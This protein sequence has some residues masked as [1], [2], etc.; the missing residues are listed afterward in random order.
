MGTEEKLEEERAVH[1]KVSD[2]SNDSG[3]VDSQSVSQSDLLGATSLSSLEPRFKPIT[4]L[5]NSRTL[6]TWR[7]YDSETKIVC[8]LKILYTEDDKL[9]N[10]F[11]SRAT[12]SMEINHPNV[13][14]TLETGRDAG[15]NPYVLMNDWDGKTLR[16]LID[17]EG[18][19]EQ[20][21]CV[22]ILEQLIGGLLEVHLHR[23]LYGC[24]TPDDIAVSNTGGGLDLVRVMNFGIPISIEQITENLP[25]A[26]KNKILSYASPE[27]CIGKTITEKSDVYSLGCI[28]FEMLSGHPPFMANQYL[29]LIGKHLVE[30]ASLSEIE[31][32]YNG[33]LRGCLKKDPNLRTELKVLLRNLRTGL[34]N[35]IESISLTKLIAVANSLVGIVGAALVAL[36][37]PKLWFMIPL[38]LLTTSFTQALSVN[39]RLDSDKTLHYSIYVLLISSV[40]ALVASAGMIYSQHAL[41]ILGISIVI[42]GVL[43]RSDKSKDIPCTNVSRLLYL[44]RMTDAQIS[45]GTKIKFLGYMITGLSICAVI[46]NSLEFIVLK[47]LPNG[48]PFQE[49]F[50]NTQILIS[51]TCLTL[52]LLLRWFLKK[53]SNRTGSLFNIEIAIVVSLIAVCES[54]KLAFGGHF[55]W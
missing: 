34:G 48:I 22:D 55:F 25:T 36:L 14:P 16:E 2:E 5:S 46:V 52:L 50:W 12:A 47:K 3:L 19:L 28:L 41:E 44:V 49:L 35:R 38:L 21:R 53:G 33:V 32:K 4:Q 8:V 23:M 45:D 17:S 54:V 18:A 43:A 51:L 26:D 13:L 11:L 15:G 9:K 6:S 1:L 7:V 31:R 27:F 29:E 40:I 20:D 10:L 42:F 24:I 39:H 30:E 37:C